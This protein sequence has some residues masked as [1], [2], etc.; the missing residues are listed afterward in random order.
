[1]CW[2]LEISKNDLSWIFVNLA[3]A[4]DEQPTKELCQF[5]G[6]TIRSS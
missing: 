1:M 3:Q 4:L 6:I 5:L 2:Y